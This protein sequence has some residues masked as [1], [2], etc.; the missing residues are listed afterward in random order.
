MLAAATLAAALI[1]PLSPGLAQGTAFTY[2]GRLNAAAGPANGNYDCTFTLFNATNSG[3]AV[4]GTITNSGTLVSNGLFQV[5]LDFGSNPYG[6]GAPLWLEI[7][8]RTNGDPAFS[9]LAPRQ[10]LTPSPYAIYAE[11]AN[12]ANLVGPVPAGNLSG[13]ALLAGGNAFSEIRL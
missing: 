12:A 1:Q 13:A 10:P 6:N 4:S 8:V 3:P 2:Q 11:W 5:A 9:T 7:G